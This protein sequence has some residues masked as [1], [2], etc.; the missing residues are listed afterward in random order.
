[1]CGNKT[2][3]FKVFSESYID[4]TKKSIWPENGKTKDFINELDIII[5][6]GMLNKIKLYWEEN[7]RDLNHE[8]NAWNF[9]KCKFTKLSNKTDQNKV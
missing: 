8:L 2:T 9:N 4:V 3:G 5:N 6:S 7:V 1:M